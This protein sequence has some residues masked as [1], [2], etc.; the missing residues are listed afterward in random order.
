MVGLLERG[1]T[2]DPHVSN[3]QS[4]AHALGVPV[5][6]LL[7][8]PAHAGKDRAP[9]EAGPA[10]AGDEERIIDMAPAAF[11]RRLSE[12][13]SNE[14]LLDLYR[15]IDAEYIDAELTYRADEDNRTAYRDYAHAI[16]R[17]MMVVLS[18]NIRGVTPPDPEQLLLQAGKLEK[19]RK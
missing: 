2:R 17:H 14:D 18:L 13:P 6:E 8:E 5:G 15:Q 16:E 9:E 3:L 7:E 12:A 19:L 11:H 1:D 4:I 10:E